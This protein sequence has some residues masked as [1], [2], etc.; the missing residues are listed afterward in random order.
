MEIKDDRSGRINGKSLLGMQS[1]RGANKEGREGEDGGVY[2][3][4]EKD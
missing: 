1:E 4:K 2:K 3:I